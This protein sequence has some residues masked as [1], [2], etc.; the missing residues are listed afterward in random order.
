MLRALYTRHA[1]PER[2]ASRCECCATAHRGVRLL[3]QDQLL[4]R[5]TAARAALTNRRCTA[6]G[7]CLL[8]VHRWTGLTCGQSS[9]YSLNSLAAT[10]GV[11]FIGV[12]GSK[13]HL[14]RFVSS[15][16]H[17]RQHRFE[18]VGRQKRQLAP[19]RRCPAA[20]VPRA[21]CRA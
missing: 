21:P 15:T 20:L 2:V 17:L 18:Q 11:D 13:L 8:L 16:S 7:Q 1:A 6:N 19:P 14:D 5:A 4:W 9:R 10:L 3:R 12:F